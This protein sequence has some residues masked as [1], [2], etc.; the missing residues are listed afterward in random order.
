MNINEADQEL[1][2]AQ[3]A[4]ETNF[5]DSSS[6]SNQN[7]REHSSDENNVE[8]DDDFVA[9]VPIILSNEIQSQPI[10]YDMYNTS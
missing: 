4:N 8:E 1:A 2:M 5:E 9:Y 6:S 3:F 10:T 7:L